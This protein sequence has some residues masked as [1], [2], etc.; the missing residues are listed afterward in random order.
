MLYILNPRLFSYNFSGHA[1]LGQ[2]V[3]GGCEQGNSTTSF[4]V[5]V[6]DRSANTLLPLI[7]RYIL[8]GSII[9]SDCWKAYNGI[10]DLPEGYTHLTVNHSEYY[11]DPNSGCCTNTIEATWR[12]LK[13]GMPLNVRQNGYEG[14][15]A[16]YLW[17]KK[18]RGQDIFM[19]LLDDISKY[20]V[21][22]HYD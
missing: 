2:W 1:V 20:H 15:L 22:S 9:Y 3:F 17:R 12:H 18:H 13:R 5:P 11:K 4:M 7:Q 16:E 10:K 8:P 6:P 14:H 19:C 21:P